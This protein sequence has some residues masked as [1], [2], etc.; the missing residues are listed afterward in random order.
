MWTD[1][2]T[3][4]WRESNYRSEHQ[5]Y[6]YLGEHGIKQES[7]AA[8]SPQQNGVAERL[9]RTLGEAA[10]SMMIHASLSN[11]YWAEAVSTATYLKNRIVT[12]ALKME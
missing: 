9:N 7:T 11:A 3:V 4:V 2:N 12:S 1:A 8:Y 5:S 6:S 10:R